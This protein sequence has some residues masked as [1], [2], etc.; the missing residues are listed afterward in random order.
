MTRIA[1]SLLKICLRLLLF[2]LLPFSSFSSQISA[3]FYG[4]YNHAVTDENT[5]Q[6]PAETDRLLSTNGRDGFVGGV[7]LGYVL[8]HFP[9]F[10]NSITLGPELFLFN[11]NTKGD[12]WQFQDPAFSNYNYSIRIK[13][14]RIMLDGWLDFKPVFWGISPL[15]GVGMGGANIKTQ[16]SD[17]VSTLG[18]QSG[19]TGGEIVLANK[20]NHKLVYSLSAGLRKQLTPNLILSALYL[21]TNFGALQ[22]SINSS[23]VTL[24]Q[25]IRFNLHTNSALLAIT[26]L[27]GSSL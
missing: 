19:I 25:P 26:Y 15:I 20:T 27:F 12:V 13:T 3:S 9:S 24:Q 5:L 7:G 8:N 22:T 1:M 16:Y 11:T 23:Q 14:T 2:I 21:Y 4:G 18:A 6:L 17:Q 10:I